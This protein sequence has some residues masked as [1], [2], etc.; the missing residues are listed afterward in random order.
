MYCSTD[1][2][3]FRRAVVSIVPVGAKVDPNIG[4]AAD[5]ASGIEA[6]LCPMRSFERIV[7]SDFATV[8]NYEFQT[9]H[10]ND[11]SG[12]HNFDLVSDASGNPGGSVPLVEGSCVIGTS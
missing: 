2:G 11:I 5:E 3:W 4:Q 7:V 8:Y 9:S 1:L 12:R 6:I 10:A